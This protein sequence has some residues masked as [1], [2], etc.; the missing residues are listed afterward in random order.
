MSPQAG[1]ATD[2]TLFLSYSHRDREMV[3]RIAR[4][5]SQ[6]GVL[7]W[8]DEAA[9]FLGDRLTERIRS[10][11]GE[12]DGV[13]VAL[14]QQALRSTWVRAEIEMTTAEEERMGAGRKL[15]LIK[16]DQCEVPSDL[17]SRAIIDLT[18]AQRYQ[19]GIN[20]LIE[21]LRDAYASRSA[22]RHSPPTWSAP[23]EAFAPVRVIKL[24]VVF[25][26][27]ATFTFPDG[28]I[29]TH[30]GARIVDLQLPTI[31]TPWALDL[32]QQALETARL[33]HFE[34][35]TWLREQRTLAQEGLRSGDRI[36]VT[37]GASAKGAAPLKGRHAAIGRALSA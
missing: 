25:Y 6:R 1:S 24:N 29:V 33:A 5:L 18:D 4:D 37:F 15:V 31:A 11:I 3:R 9:L 27:G 32:D 26:D 34:S 8:L 14:S 2:P 16:V 30:D 19:I 28:L 17:T 13:A 20:R 21:R 22:A 36:I 35:R 12:V 23:E 10:A 7:V